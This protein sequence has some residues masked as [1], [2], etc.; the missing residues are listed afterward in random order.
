MKSPRLSKTLHPPDLVLLSDALSTKY[1]SFVDE[2][3]R[4]QPPPKLELPPIVVAKSLCVCASVPFL[5]VA[6][7]NDLS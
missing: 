6:T 1:T 5:Y 2:L 4:A 7:W 3:Y